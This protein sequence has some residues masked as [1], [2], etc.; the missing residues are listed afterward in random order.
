[1]GTGKTTVG[2]LLATT[3]GYQFVDTDQLIEAK[4]DKTIPQIFSEDGEPH[5]RDLERQVAL[6]LSARSRLVVSTGGGMLMNEVVA[7]T[8]A[9]TGAIFCLVA[10]PQEIL[11]RV[12]ENGPAHDR[13]LLAGDDPAGKIEA[14]LNA[15]RD[16]YG[17]F[18]Q[19]QTDSLSPQDVVH[20]IVEQLS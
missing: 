6:E 10:S 4:S 16:R 9:K 20:S 14:L 12:T 5:F 15:R 3:L 1:M 2:R 11:R 19:I 13:P 18:T 8:F 17:R 7:D